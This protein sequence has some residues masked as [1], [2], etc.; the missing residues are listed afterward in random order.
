MGALQWQHGRDAI[1]GVRGGAFARGHLGLRW[2][3]MGA[4]TFQVHNPA[5]GEVLATLPAHGRTETVA[6]VA[7][8][9]QALAAECPAAQRRAWLAEIAATLV[10]ER[11][12][13][14]RT[15][16]GEQGKPLAEARAE[17]DYAAGFFQFFASQLAALA[18]RQLPGLIGGAAWTIEQRPAGVVALITPWNFPLAMLAKKLAAALAAGCTMV[19][20]PSELTPL[21]AIALGRILERVGVPPGRFNLVHGPAGPIGQVFCEHPAVRVISFTGSTRTGQW[22]LAAAAPQVKRLALEL[23]G[24]APFLVFADADLDGAAAALVANKFR[25]AGQTCVCAN[26]IYVAHV[27]AERFTALVDKRV[28]ELKVGNGSEPGVQLGP[29][30]DRAGFDKVR[31]H[32]ADA[33]ARGARLVSGRLPDPPV[34]AWGNFFPPVV[35]AGVTQDMA[36]VREETFGPVVPLA[37]FTTEAEVLAAANGT[38]YGLAAYVFTRDPA[39]AERCARGLQFGHVALNSGTGP[40]PEAPFGGMKMSGFG[41]EGG[42]EG[43]LE[44]CEVQTVARGTPDAG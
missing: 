37:E 31:Q 41:R 4:P 7:C 11:D 12:E 18:P 13:L 38:P 27:V 14:A 36:V 8:A 2:K 16:T 24:N 17:V 43:L 3:G 44:Y 5:T 42:V 35:L 6:A 40:T 34:T 29:L 1:H 22:L 25:C 15:I 32:C 39:L 19:A 28:R 26:R 10:R 23:G 9:A 33:L 30:I 20:K 21:S